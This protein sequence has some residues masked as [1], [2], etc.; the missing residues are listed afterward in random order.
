MQKNMFLFNGAISVLVSLAAAC[1]GSG[2]EGVDPG[3][4]GPDFTGKVEPRIVGAYAMKRQ[5]A[6]IQTLPILGM[7]ASITISY[8]MGKIARQGDVFTLTESVCRVAPT[9]SGSVTTTIDDGVPR[10]TPAATVSLDVH[11]DGANVVWSRPS[12]P[13]VLGARLDN[14]GSDTLPSMASDPRVFDQDGD[15][16]PGVT[17]HIAGLVSG[18]VYVAQREKSSYAGKLVADGQLTGLV[19][20]TSEQMV[21]DASNTLL[22][23]NVPSMPDPDPQ[24]S[25]VTLK[26]VESEWDCDKLVAQI[27]TVFP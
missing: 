8:G 22:N 27:A 11:P 15:G 2:T 21:L 24:K 5:T 18:D 9:S 4:T 13:L 14:P 23:Q 3:P 20:G 16:H 1:G 7:Q 19:T 12:A 17:A 26:R 10:S 25:N 6:A